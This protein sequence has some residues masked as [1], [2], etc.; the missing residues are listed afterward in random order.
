MNHICSLSTEYKQE[1]NSPPQ[2]AGLS[3]NCTQAKQAEFLWQDRNP[4]L[5]LPKALPHTM[6]KPCTQLAESVRTSRQQPQTSKG[7][8]VPESAMLVTPAQHHYAVLCKRN[9]QAETPT[10]R[11]DLWHHSL[12]YLKDMMQK[13]DYILEPTPRENT[14]PALPGALCFHLACTPQ[15]LL[16]H[17]HILLAGQ[18]FFFQ[19]NNFQQVL[20]SLPSL[21]DNHCIGLH[22]YT[23]WIS[24]FRVL[25][26]TTK[27]YLP[28]TTTDSSQRQAICPKP[29]RK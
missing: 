16:R 26:M 9:L 14:S 10:F 25:N 5:F 13:W 7:C 20:D 17:W 2:T 12:Q 22:Y 18:V 28:F 4:C 19:S 24:V 3:S 29:H 11:E 23:S 6:E 27:H 21:N 8:Y 15:H 1:Q